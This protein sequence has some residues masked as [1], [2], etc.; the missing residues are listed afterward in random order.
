MSRCFR[1]GTEYKR[2]KWVKKV[3]L[4]QDVRVCEH[5]RAIKGG[6]F[7]PGD[8]AG[9]IE[10]GEQDRGVYEVFDGLGSMSMQTSDSGEDND[11]EGDSQKEDGGV[12][13]AG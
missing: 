11:I 4:A 2:H 8:Q 6:I 13:A 1:N 3:A 12:E 9:E 10:G 7:E 5:C